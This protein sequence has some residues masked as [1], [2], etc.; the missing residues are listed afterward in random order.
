[1]TAIDTELYIKFGLIYLKVKAS[2]DKL[3]NL[4]RIVN[5]TM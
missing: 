2:C 1:V 4:F 3:R 5:S